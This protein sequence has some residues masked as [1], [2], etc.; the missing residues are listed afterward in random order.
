MH[1]R[2]IP[3]TCNFSLYILIIEFKYVLL[4]LGCEKLE[5]INPKP[6]EKGC[7]IFRTV[8]GKKPSLSYAE[9]ISQVCELFWYL[10]WKISIWSGVKNSVGCCCDSSSTDYTLIR[11]SFNYHKTKDCYTCMC[12]QYFYKGSETCPHEPSA[13]L[14]IYCFL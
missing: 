6:A 7:T 3:F 13:N 5:K 2:W 9:K 8:T 4:S 14:G 12:V 11:A 1:L 10:P